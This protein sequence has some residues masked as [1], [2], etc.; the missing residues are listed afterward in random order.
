MTETTID[1]IRHGEPEGGKRY[2]GQLDDPLSNRGWEQMRRAVGG[3]C[4]WDAIVSSPLVRCAAFAR[5]VSE[6]HGLPLSLDERLME[7]GFGAWEGR[8][9]AELM[10]EE[11]DVL[12]RFWSDPLHH[13]P[14]GAETLT[15]F[16]DRVVAAWE[17]TLA[18]H[19]GRHIL[20]V[21][22]AG[23]MRL[24][25]SHVLGMPVERMFRIQVEN[26]GITRIR[27]DGEG[28]HALPRLLFHG[29]VLPG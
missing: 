15:A 24:V 18:R 1:M 3:L 16:R 14:P 28:E 4:P 6:R 29:A 20:L 11:P 5:E 27:V 26:A 22:H 19:R 10:A 17:E 25:I 8:T 13:T 9:A 7:I 23:Q 21:G 2:R 12:M